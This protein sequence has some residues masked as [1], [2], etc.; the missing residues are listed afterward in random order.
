MAQT[1]V[2]FLSANGARIPVVGLGTWELRGRTCARAV[3]QALRLGYRH[4]DTAEM[5][6]NERE[7][8]EGLR[9][10]GVNRDDVFITTKVWPSH[11]APRE[12]ERSAKESVARLRVSQV[13]LLLL[14][15]PSEQIPLSETMPALC[16][17]KQIGLTRHIGISNFTVALVA[18]AVR[19][20]SEPLVT[21][22]IE[23]HPYLDQ[24]KVIAACRRHGISITAYSPIARGRV[25]S[26]K[27][28]KRI[29]QAHGKTASQAALR[30][31]IQR[32][33]V[34]IPRTS[35]VE[36]LAENLALFDFE[37]T[38]GEVE[39]ISALAH[40]RGRMVDWG[41]GPQWD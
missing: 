12:L 39:E 17:M 30:W 29:G 26:D 14:H 33:I 5:Y 19:L 3:E 1:A 35:K 36:R 20:A 16:K 27:L 32:N 18:E 2:P 7:V 9:A 24:S 31:L 40:P 4:I 41:G 34:V 37:L 23:C 6:D 21:N 13:D 22:Q 11:F 8:G 15:W 28:L 25:S 38:P 10:S